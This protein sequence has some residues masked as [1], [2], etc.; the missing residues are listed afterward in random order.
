MALVVPT[1]VLVYQA[2]GQLKWEAF[3]QHRV[4]AEEFADRIDARVRLWIST[5]EAR[6]LAD[7][8]FLVVQGEARANFVQRSPLSSFPVDA[9]IP[10]LVSYFQIDADGTFSTPLLPAGVDPAT[11]GVAADEIT[12]RRALEGRVRALLT[13]PQSTADARR[14][15]AEGRASDAEKKT[16][17]KDEVRRTRRVRSAERSRLRRDR[18]AENCD[19][20]E[21]ARPR[22]RPEARLQ[23]RSARA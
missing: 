18:S 15:A 2:F 4:L 3:Y 10:G 1:A 13:L 7:Y 23:I 12:Q 9:A 5:E 17:A 20:D 21:P 8:R 6:S 19:S 16:L 11:Y 22:R 14:D